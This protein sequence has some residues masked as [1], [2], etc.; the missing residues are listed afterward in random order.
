MC[1]KFRKPKLSFYKI[2][3]LMLI[4]ALVLLDIAWAGSMHILKND[5]N[6]DTLSPV[7]QIQ[8]TII[9]ETFITRAQE[10]SSGKVY[11]NDVNALSQAKEN[12]VEQNSKNIYAGLLKR[13]MFTTLIS[14]ALISIKLF[15]ITNSFFLSIALFILTLFPHKFFFSNIFTLFQPVSRKFI[16]N[17]KVNTPVYRN[18]RLDNANYKPENSLTIM[19]PVYNESFD[20]IKKT[21]DSAVKESENYSREKTNIVVCDDGLMAFCDNDLAVFMRESRSRKRKGLENSAEQE[22]VIQRMD[23]Y[24]KLLKRSDIHFSIVARP[25]PVAGQPETER[26]GTF[27]KG[28][29]LNYTHR[30]YDEISNL[31][32]EKGMTLRKA[33]RIVSSRKKY[34]SSFVQ[35]GLTIGDIVLL[36]DK[37]TVIAPGISREAIPE[38]KED[39][40]LSYIQCAQKISNSNENYFTQIIGYFT[41]IHYKFAFPL[42]VLQGSIV[43]LVGHGV[44]IKTSLLKNN[45]YWAEDKASED[46]SLSLDLVAQGYHGK[47]LDINGLE[48]SEEVT[49]GFEDEVGRHA[50]YAYGAGE[51]F[52][53]PLRYWFKKGILSAQI[54]RFLK[55]SFVPWQVKADVLVYLGT[56][57]YAMLLLPYILCSAFLPL[58]YFGILGPIII[59]WIFGGT[60]I[61]L[62]FSNRKQGLEDNHPSALKR[63]M[64]HFWK[65]F[66]YGAVF[67]GNWVFV[68]KGMFV[69]LSNIKPNFSATSVGNLEQKPLKQILKESSNSIIRA[70]L[71]TSIFVGGYLVRYSIT[72]TLPHY[73]YTAC[74]LCANLV[75]SPFLLN[76]ELMRAM[77]I[78]F[79]TMLQNIKKMALSAGLF[80]KK[81]VV[82]LLIILFIVLCAGK[83]CLGNDNLD[84]TGDWTQDLITAWQLFDQGRYEEAV[85]MTDI[86]LGEHPD[87]IVIADQQSNAA[88]ENGG[89]PAGIDNLKYTWA[90]NDVAG[91]YFLKTKSYEQLGFYEDLQSAVETIND[92]PYA[93]IW[94]TNGWSW[95]PIE[96]IRSDYP[97]IVEEVFVDR[98]WS[99]E[100]EGELIKITDNYRFINGEIWRMLY[101]GDIYD[102]ESWLEII[103]TTIE[104]SELVDLPYYYPESYDWLIENYNSFANYEIDDISFNFLYDFLNALNDMLYAYEETWVINGKLDIDEKSLEYLDALKM[105]LTGLM[106]KLHDYAWMFEEEPDEVKEVIEKPEIP[107]E[108]VSEEIDNNRELVSIIEQEEKLEKQIKHHVVKYDTNFEQNDKNYPASVYFISILA[109]LGVGL[110]IYKLKRKQSAKSKKVSKQKSEVIM[111]AKKGPLAISMKKISIQTQNLIYQ[112]I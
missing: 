108:L 105:Q 68:Y 84:V 90:M 94:D 8:E 65:S 9:Q 27:K 7:L 106:D 21:I 24:K 77:A 31:A 25:K 73:F 16:L 52:L 55:S 50:R 38:F 15:F 76:P 2:T 56:Y 103:K 41:N 46:L 61:L 1:I 102:A 30:L 40:S 53:R 19:I 85:D 78:E 58:H 92:Y 69:Y 39:D 12:K 5:K 74:F 99:Q 110:T 101:E 45:G 112:A 111:H 100:E 80:F 95:S 109:I 104:T 43:P 72:N 97:G 83:Q 107:T 32:K 4:Y 22:E 82:V 57:F 34:D 13:V 67:T 14:S 96:E 48:F 20:V 75:L 17:E 63:L 71:F 29:N 10:L 81:G 23:L 64:N 60:M 33:Q 89:A 44:Y 28:S 86:L 88:I 42:S 91:L 18:H 49:N 59:F 54:K 93:R 62:Y 87:I 37:D 26:A 70:F 3:A 6:A 11:I 98:N 35:G 47:Y 36:L 51:I 66:S 79:K